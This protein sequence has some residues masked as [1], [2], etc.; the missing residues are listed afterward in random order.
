MCSVV[1][2]YPLLVIPRVVLVS[3]AA[4]LG[5]FVA[6][7]LSVVTVI[8]LFPLFGILI[9][10]RSAVLI[11]FAFLYR[12]R[13]VKIVHLLR[14]VCLRLGR[15]KA[16]ANRFFLAVLWICVTTLELALHRRIA[17]HI[18]PVRKAL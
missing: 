6:L 13:I 12:E 5:T 11:F 1:I 17:N 18:S 14:V 9:D 2:E 7:L 16:F 3:K 4:V 10:G 15:V 8:T